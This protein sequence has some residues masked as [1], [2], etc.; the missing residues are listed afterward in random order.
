MLLGRIS[1]RIAT[2]RR[3][4]RRRS[5][6][7]IA[8]DVPVK[9]RKEEGPAVEQREDEGGEQP[10]GGLGLPDDHVL[11][12]ISHEMGNYFHK[13]YY[14][15]DYLKN[16][17]GDT[18]EQ[19]A[20]EMLEGTVERLERF[21]RMILE[22]FAPARLC[23]A[24]VPVSELIG[25]MESQLIGRRLRVEGDDLTD[26]V[27]MVDPSLIAH[28]LRITFERATSTL[29][30]EPEMSVRVSKTRRGEYEGIEIEFLVGKESRDQAQLM[31]GIEMVVA[32]KFFQMHGGELFEREGV[33]HALVV[34]LPLYA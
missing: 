21:M 5:L 3:S 23:F 20:V 22:Y 30:D 28:A 1:P 15:T 14:W 27:V 25:S 17:V 11:G 10:A 7:C 6:G 24:K 2:D 32:E 33:D 34:F 9:A 26:T 8:A 19:G 29:L 12:E 13:L 31:K 4:D 18:G 16:S